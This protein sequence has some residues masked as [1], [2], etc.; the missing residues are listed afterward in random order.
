M[1]ITTIRAA[2][3]P[4]SLQNSLRI[5]GGRGS[6]AADHQLAAGMV[7][8]D[9]D[10]RRL[11]RHGLN[12][13]RLQE[14]IGGSLVVENDVT[15]LFK[16]TPNPGSRYDEGQG[17]QREPKEANDAR[18]GRTVVGRTSCHLI[19]DMAKDAREGSTTFTY[20]RPI[21]FQTR[22]G[23]ARVHYSV[24]LAGDRRSSPSLHPIPF[25]T[26]LQVFET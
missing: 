16:A 18:Y 1:G 26:I 3:P 12:G 17:D 21:H 11:Q 24:R 15:P 9:L 2:G 25:G 7:L 13:R 8:D 6:T 20:A 10:P 23:T 19:L 22:L 5:E 14:V 4:A